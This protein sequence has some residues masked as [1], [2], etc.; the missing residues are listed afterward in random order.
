M[1]HLP[2]NLNIT[3]VNGIIFIP[4]ISVFSFLQR[5]MVLMK[6]F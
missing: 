4:F 6:A 3:F 5:Q 1:N 2:K